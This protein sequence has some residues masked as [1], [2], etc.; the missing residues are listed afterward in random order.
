MTRLGKFTGRIYTGKY[1]FSQCPECCTIIP[2]DKANDEAFINIHRAGDLLDCLRCLGCPA[3][4]E[5]IG[6]IE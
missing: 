4:K 1:D 3:A 2:D 5:K 6:I